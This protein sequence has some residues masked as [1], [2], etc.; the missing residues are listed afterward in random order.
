MYIIGYVSNTNAK[1]LEMEHDGMKFTALPDNIMNGDAVVGSFTDSNGLS[2]LVY[3]KSLYGGYIVDAFID[4]RMYNP[5]AW[6]E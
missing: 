1:E 5:T 4:S 6:T 2:H 3:R